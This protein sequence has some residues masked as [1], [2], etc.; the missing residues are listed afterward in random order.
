MFS[1][2]LFA[3]V[4]ASVAS[5]TKSLSIS[6]SAP[7]SLTD[8]SALEVVTTI[9]NTG[10]ETVTLLNDPRTVLSSWATQSFIITG[11]SG[12]EADFTGVAVRYIPEVVA[13][14]AEKSVTILAAGESVDV[15]HEVG[16]FYNFTSA[17]E[18]AFTV[19]PLTS[20]HAIEEDGTLTTIEATSSA[21]SLHLTGSLSSAKALS[22][23]SLG[24]TLTTT[25][26]SKRASYNSCS[27]TR[28]TQNNA[29]I[30]AASALAS[31][32]VSHLQ[33]NPSG[34]TLQTTWYGAFASSRYSGTLASFKTLESAP[35]GWWYDCTCTDADTYAYVYPSSYGEVYLCGY[36]WNAPA[37]GAGSRADT[38]I[39]EGTHFP[40]VLGTDDYAYGESACKSLASSSPA[41]AYLNAELFFF[42]FVFLEFV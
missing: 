33:S 34:S 24:G 20:F 16:N 5:A 32:S 19:T 12:V 4:S 17:G 1:S 31:A 40:E 8:V 35:A 3:L 11:E 26:L 22:P 30:S 28:Q 36:Y 6:T 25:G 10:D 38:I 29:A 23:S 27:S 2:V 13:Q 42:F 37:T 39:H 14:K 41:R 18:G 21:A 9:T 15:T 7:A